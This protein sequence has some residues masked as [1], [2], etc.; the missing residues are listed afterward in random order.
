ATVTT[1]HT[2]G[3]RAGRRDAERAKGMKLKKQS[4]GANPDI[5]SFFSLSPAAP[6][7][8]TK[9]KART[10]AGSPFGPGSRR[11]SGAGTP[12]TVAGTPPPLTPSAV[13]DSTAGAASPSPAPRG[14][15]A[16]ASGIAGRTSTKRVA[17]S[18][19]TPARARKTPPPRPTP[20]PEKEVV[21]LTESP[22]SAGARGRGSG[23]GG[24]SIVDLRARSAISPAQSGTAATATSS[25]P[26][27]LSGDAKENG[28]RGSVLKTP[29]GFPSGARTSASGGMATSAAKAAAGAAVVEMSGFFLEG[30]SVPT[31]S[32]GGGGGG[33]SQGSG[34]S[35]EGNWNLPSARY[36]VPLGEVVLGRDSVRDSSPANSNKL[37]LGIDKR[38]E[39]VSRSQ[40]T[41]KACVAEGRVL[42]THKKGAVNGIRIVRWAGSAGITATE[43]AA[44]RANTAGAAKALRSGELLQA[45][46][47]SHLYPGDTLQLDGFR[48]PS[49]S[50]CSYVLHPLPPGWTAPL[51]RS[52]S[53]TSHPATSPRK[54][55]ASSSKK[56]GA[57]AAAAAAAAA[58]AGSVGAGGAGAV[59]VDRK[60]PV[61]TGAGADPQAKK[62]SPLWKEQQHPLPK[63]KHLRHR[64]GR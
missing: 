38:E 51:T 46:R 44:R 1:G 7:N 26:G 63:V 10:T 61:K 34:G 54:T 6:S 64:R 45:G 48:V 31:K 37:R 14:T 18:P 50:T 5:R 59:A 49:S 24:S 4:S 27:N 58:A 3:Q 25:R 35:A 43:K 29:A 28:I 53:L 17:A 20:P 39:G 15:A 19:L 8:T 56:A 22:V 57:G 36:A 23:G 9:S 62:A 16:A 33:G 13:T 60:M 12:S 30:P 41:L 55:P 21:C 47:Q 42:V 11:S 32:G 52:G 40:A 2:S